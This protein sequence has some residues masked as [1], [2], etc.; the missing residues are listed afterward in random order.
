MTGTVDAAASGKNT[1]TITWVPGQDRMVGVCHCGARRVGE[2]PVE[3]WMWLLGHPVEHE[4][5]PPGAA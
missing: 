1:Y 3:L 4:A 5:P 2:D